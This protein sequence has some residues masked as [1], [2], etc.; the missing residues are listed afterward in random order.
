MT[1]R[2]TTPEWMDL[3]QLTTYASV[4]ERTLRGWIHA[5]LNPLPAVRVGGKVLVRRSVFDAWLESHALQ[6]TG[7]VEATVEEILAGVSQ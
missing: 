7:T 1:V 2:I 3:K 6:P 4:S 5:L